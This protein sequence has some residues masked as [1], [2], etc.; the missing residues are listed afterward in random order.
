MAENELKN[1][2]SVG[3]SHKKGFAKFGEKIKAG[4]TKFGRGF[5]SLP[6]NFVKLCVK[7]GTGVRDGVKNYVSIFREGDLG[8]RLSFVVMGAGAFARKQIAKGV[9]YLAIQLLFIFYMIFNGAG[10]IRGFFTLGTEFTY[11][12]H[13]LNNGTTSAVQGDNS[14]LCLLF[15]VVAIAVIVAFIV[16]YF[17]NIRS[18]NE[19]Y[20]NSIVGRKLPTFK[21]DLKDLFDNKFY[22]VLLAVALIGVIAFTVLPLVFMILIAFTNFDQ[23]HSA[24]SGFNWVGLDNFKSL[25]G[26]T[27]LSTTFF[28]VLGWTL[29]WALCATFLNYFLGVALALLINKKDIKGQKVWRTFFV[30]TIAIP[31]FVSLLLMRQLLGPFGPIMELF[32]KTGTDLFDNTNTARMIIILVNLW[33]GIPYSMLITSGILMNIPADLYESARIDGAGKLTMFR[34]ITLPYILFVTGPYLITQ[35]IGN[36]NNFNIIYLLTGGGPFGEAG[37]S[38]GAGGT[39]LLVTWLYTMTGNSNYKLAS[40]LGILTFIVCSIVSLITYRNSSASKNEEDF[41]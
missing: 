5:V 4:L 17:S 36:I 16:M 12:I 40:T 13:Y 11:D 37:Y 20:E 33:I 18:A 35:F 34:K 14:M 24:T 22:V 10:A 21:D 31:Q 29:L 8:V 6:K 2:N 7:I 41:Q 26:T 23:D 38:D 27:G 15:G 19:A 32:G 25:V 28:P 30:L 39:S 3:S 1:K 9:T